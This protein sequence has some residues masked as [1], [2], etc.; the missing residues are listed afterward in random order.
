[1]SASVHLDGSNAISDGSAYL[2]IAAELLRRKRLPGI[3]RQPNL[4]VILAPRGVGGEV[5][6][7]LPMYPPEEFLKHAADCEQMAKFTRDPVSK[8]T[9][10]GMAE[11]WLRC[12]ELAKKQNSAARYRAPSK[13]SRRGVSSSWAE[14]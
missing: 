14:L 4:Q 8:A 10:S 1:L 3:A 2:L 12:A 6:E 7:T 5:K 13:Q 9:W 11:R